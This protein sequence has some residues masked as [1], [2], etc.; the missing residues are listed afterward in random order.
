MRVSDHELEIERGRYTHPKTKIED[1]KC[2]H[3]NAVEDEAHF[4]LECTTYNLD[5]ETLFAALP[6]IEQRKNRGELKATRHHRLQCRYDSPRH[7][8]SSENLLSATKI[9]TSAKRWNTRAKLNMPAQREVLFSIIFFVLLFAQQLT[10]AADTDTNEECSKKC[11]DD[12]DRIECLKICVSNSNST[13]NDDD[14]EKRSA[15][16][17]IGRGD[18]K[19]SAFWRIGRSGEDM[20]DSD[21]ERKKAFWRIGRD[22]NKKSAFWR[23][24]RSDNDNDESKKSAFWRIGRADQ[25]FAPQ[26]KSAF[27]RIGR[28]DPFDKRGAFWRIGKKSAFWRIGKKEDYGSEHDDDDKRSAFWRIGKRND[29]KDMKKSAFW[30]IG[31]SEANSHTDDEDKKSAFW[32][33]GKKNGHH[34][35]KRDTPFWRIGRSVSPIS[36]GFFDDSDDWRDGLVVGDDDDKR[37]TFWRIGKRPNTFWRV[38]RSND[39]R[40]FWRI[41]KRDPYGDEDPTKRLNTFWRVGR[42]FPADTDHDLQIR[43]FWRIG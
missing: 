23:I 36:P 1:R 26:K 31:R 12:F 13:E 11:S 14:D 16:W 19:K 2:P 39:K 35:Q 25:E 15:F 40:T 22:P 18:D 24:G 30:R 42:S 27:W 29:D 33:I 43:S 8:L 9:S 17:R 21:N 20:T 41:G 5:R 3:C 6:E 37:S 4:F 28:S 7:H 34:I 10:L 32:R 38:G